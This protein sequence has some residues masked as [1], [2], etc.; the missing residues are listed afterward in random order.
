[1]PDLQPKLSASA[2]IIED[3][4]ENNINTEGFCFYVSHKHRF[5]SPKTTGRGVKV[6]DGRM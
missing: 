4:P 5:I 1:M 6:F 2:Q 3:K